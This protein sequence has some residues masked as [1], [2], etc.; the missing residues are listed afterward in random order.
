MA[1]GIP[2]CVTNWTSSEVAKASWVVIQAGVRVLPFVTGD[3][4][5]TFV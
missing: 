3:N 4:L 5:L 1:S 2:N